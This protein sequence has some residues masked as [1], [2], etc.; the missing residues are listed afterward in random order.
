[1]A[2]GANAGVPLTSEYL[3]GLVALSSLPDV[4]AASMGEKA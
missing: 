4:A 3:L 2:V 1:M